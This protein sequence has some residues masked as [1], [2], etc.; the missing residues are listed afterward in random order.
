MAN[1]IS[2]FDGGVKAY[3]DGIPRKENPYVHLESD[4]HIKWDQGWCEAY[5][6]DP[7]EINQKAG[8]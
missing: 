4:N 3:C 5:M 7:D 6:V 8:D 2:I 1:D